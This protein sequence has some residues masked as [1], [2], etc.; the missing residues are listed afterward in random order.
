MAVLRV[1]LDQ[2]NDV[3]EPD[4]AD[5]ARSLVRALAATAPP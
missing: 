5:A 4:Q 1:V 3:V 2:V